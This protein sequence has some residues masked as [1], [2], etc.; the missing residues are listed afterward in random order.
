PL[1]E[2]ED[3]ARLIRLLPPFGQVGLHGEAA[4]RHLPADLVAQQLAVDEAQRRHGHEIARLVRVEVRGI[5]AAYAEGSAALGLFGEKR[6]GS[7]KGQRRTASD[8]A[9]QKIAAA[10]IGAVT[11]CAILRLHS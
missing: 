7:E 10:Q 8:G 1:V 6:R 9:L 2:M 11:K 3:V 5:P 4:R